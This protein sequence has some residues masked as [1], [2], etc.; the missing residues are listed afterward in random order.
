MREEVKRFVRRAPALRKRDIEEINGLFQHY[1]FLRGH[2]AWTSC[3]R[4]HETLAAGDPLLFEPHVPQPKPS[5]GNRYP[6]IPIDKKIRCPWC[7]AMAAVKRLQ[8]CGQ[9]KNLWEEQRVL[10]LRWDGKAL[11]ALAAWMSKDY[12]GNLTEAPK[13]M[14]GSTYRFTDK[15]AEWCEASYLSGLEYSYLREEKYSLFTGKLV[16]E[17]FQWGSKHGNEYNVIGLDAL[18]KSPVRYCEIGGNKFIKRLHLAFVYPQ[19]VE[20]LQ[21]ARM[22]CCIKDYVEQRK[23]NAAL[24]DW[25][26]TKPGNFLRL[27]GQERK[28]F[29]SLPEP[30]PKIIE[31]KRAME[32]AGDRPSMA[33]AEALMADFEW[34]KLLTLCKRWGVRPMRAARWL[35][36]QNKNPN[37]A[38]Y[39]WQDY[40]EHGAELGY[41][42]HRD[43]VLMPGN[44]GEA[45]DRAAAEYNARRQEMRDKAKA[46]E[47]CRAKEDYM[48][49]YAQLR[50]KYEYA[51]GGYIIRVPR[52]GEEITEEGRVLKH[53]VAGY[54]QPHLSGATTILFLRRERKP[55]TPFLTIEMW[56]DKLQ[57]IHGYKNEGQYSYA[58]RFAADPRETF[59]WMLDPWLDWVKRGSKRNEDGSPK[60]PKHKK[61]EEQ[62][63]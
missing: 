44:L 36:E 20:M 57:Q 42:M 55:D 10:L 49:R 3:C 11:W 47:L 4:R 28:E 62:T 45:H 26:A 38:L 18:D 13:A 2:E 14:A 52:S 1:I 25:N 39:A 63:A 61:T 60:L 30:K 9:R 46:E 19:K 33:E 31:A 51:A 40:V 17:P 22:G 53:C 15:G 35:R 16:P 27:K 50:E 59:R 7:G 43:N 34:R 23:K 24:L 37:I 12:S 48:T 29:L 8:Y 32:R 41:A 54:A 58:G 6:H 5:M 21:K 56:G